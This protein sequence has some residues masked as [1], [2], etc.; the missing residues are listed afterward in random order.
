MSKTVSEL[1]L[2][3]IW[4]GTFQVELMSAMKS[5]R[6]RKGWSVPHSLVLRQD[7]DQVSVQH[8]EGGLR[9]AD[10]PEL[11]AGVAT[12]VFHQDLRAA[13]VLKKRR[14]TTVR[15]SKFDKIKRILA[16]TSLKN[17]VRS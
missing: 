17:S 8:F 15:V 1:G 11:V 2:I 13:R 3:I 6:G 12:A 4:Y 5:Y 14:F 7:A 10:T 9:V 16:V